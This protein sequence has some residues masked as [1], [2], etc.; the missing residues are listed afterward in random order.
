MSSIS[1]ERPKC[2]VCGGFAI[3]DG[4]CMDCYPFAYFQGKRCIYTGTSEVLHGQLFYEVI[5]LEG[6]RKD[7]STWIA[8]SPEYW[9][10]YHERI[11]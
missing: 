2:K 10:E 3:A 8:Q 9:R 7:K 11:R 5:P 6:E 4:Y 1:I